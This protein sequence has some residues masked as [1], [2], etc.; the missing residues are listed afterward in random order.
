MTYVLVALYW[1]AEDKITIGTDNDVCTG[2]A[3]LRCRG[4]NYYWDRQWRMYWWRCI[5]V[6]RTGLLLGR[7]M[8]YVLV[9][10]YW[11]AEDRIT[12]GTD[13]DV[14]TGG[15]VLRCRGQDYYW[16][17]QWR[18]YWWRCIEVQ[19]TEFPCTYTPYYWGGKWRVDHGME[20]VQILTDCGF[21][22]AMWL[23]K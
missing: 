23:F 11:G 16:D 19:R 10:L 6:Q 3:V 20:Y 5:E 13:N 22:F 4:Q 8:T 12:I 15:A 18:M 7:T 1:G 14:C 2:G 21:T 9:A 17:G